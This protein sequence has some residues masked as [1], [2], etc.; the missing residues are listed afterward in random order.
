MTTEPTPKVVKMV[1]SGLDLSMN[2]G[3]K[4]QTRR[5]MPNGQGNKGGNGPAPTVNLG[6][7]FVWLDNSRFNDN[8]NNGALL[9]LDASLEIVK[10]RK[11]PPGKPMMNHHQ[12]PEFALGDPGDQIVWVD[13]SRF[14]GNGYNGLEANLS[15]T[16][17][18]GQQNTRR[19]NMQGPGGPKKDPADM[20]V[21]IY[22]ST[23]DEN[24]YSGAKVHMDAT[25]AEIVDR[26][27]MP[28]IAKGMM[29]GGPRGR[30]EN[31]QDM[32]LEV[33]SSDL[34]GNRGSGLYAHLNAEFDPAKQRGPQKPPMGPPQRP[35][36]LGSMTVK[37]LNSILD[38]NGNGGLYADLTAGESKSRGKGKGSKQPTTPFT[39]GDMKVK[40]VD[41]SFSYNRGD[42]AN[43]HFDANDM[44]QA[45]NM[46]LKVDY[47]DFIR[48]RRGDGLDVAMHTEAVQID[49]RKPQMN[50]NPMPVRDEGHK[51]L[52]KI[53]DS[54][55]NGNGRNGLRVDMAHEPKRGKGKG[56]GRQ[57]HSEAGDMVVKLTDSRFNRNNRNGALITM[58]ADKGSS[59]T[60]QKVVSDDS[61]FNG[62]GRNGLNV[63]ME[64][65]GNAPKRPVK[66]GKGKGKND[67]G[68]VVRLIDSRFT[69]NRRNGARVKI[70]NQTGFPADSK[71][72]AD[73]SVFDGNFLDGLRVR[74]L[75]NPQR[76]GMNGQPIMIGQRTEETLVKLLNSDF[77]GNR[78]GAGAKIVVENN[79][80]NSNP[81]IQVE[82]DNSLFAGNGSKGLDIDLRKGGN[83]LVLASA[84]GVPNVPPVGYGILDW[85][86]EI[87]DS[88]F[89]FNRGGGVDIDMI[90]NN[91]YS[92]VP[93]FNV[94]ID[95]SR[96]RRNFGHG[97]DVNMENNGNSL[98]VMPAPNP[99]VVANNS[100]VRDNG[101]F[102][103]DI[104][105]SRIIN[106]T[107]DGA[108]INMFNGAHEHLVDMDF[109]ADRNRIIRN[110]NGI[111][112][113]MQNGNNTRPIAPAS[114][115]PGGHS[116]MNIEITRS[117]IGF[118]RQDGADLSALNYNCHH[119]VVQDGSV[120]KGVKYF[121]N[122][123]V[124]V[125]LNRF[126][127]RP[128]NGSATH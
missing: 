83:P 28:A 128:C 33:I 107:G 35:V 64:K 40:L 97:V 43:V 121:R 56:K 114:V 123:G 77:T 119:T 104:T 115:V 117:F 61:G 5:G 15:S 81:H 112:V 2:S 88:G 124:P 85:D 110:R 66:I 25:V 22:N 94:D 113:H 100:E 57:P 38:E 58:D 62:N 23:F 52:V 4:K 36:E 84:N 21:S 98:I 63:S 82:V 51:K 39:A 122:R 93:D 72:V 10:D 126:N 54:Y 96:F 74:V 34:I 9:N 45:P 31:P 60:L 120:R 30:N 86:V 14:D 42:G 76:G 87:K 53:N 29:P 24:G 95:N 65:S 111:S 109:S 6:D 105:R 108:H 91:D 27:T 19:T 78:K 44:E 20:V 46:T 125:D 37:V 106:N 8:Q 80:P 90:N 69:G 16:I 18:T 75:Q 127:A 11:G 89:F 26:K 7:Q 59:E 99:T 48:N 32:L 50:M 13:D 68:Q 41:S 73:N 79:T 3:I 17:S 116:H 71:V 1:Y 49:G 103:V 92:S 55:F 12:K 118:N 67:F 102:N 47:S 70:D 101:T